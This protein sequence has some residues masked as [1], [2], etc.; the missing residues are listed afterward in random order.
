MTNDKDD[1]SD[2]PVIAKARAFNGPL[3]TYRFLVGRDGTV[4]IYDSIATHYTLHHGLPPAAEQRLRRLAGISK[5][6]RSR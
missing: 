4:W 2:I 6:K 3:Q 1:S 5:P